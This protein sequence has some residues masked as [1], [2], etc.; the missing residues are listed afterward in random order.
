MVRLPLPADPTS[1]GWIQYAPPISYHTIQLA[2]VTSSQQIIHFITSQTLQTA[3][4]HK[5]ILFC[6]LA[7]CE[8]GFADIHAGVSGRP[9]SGRSTYSV[10][11]YIGKTTSTCTCSALTRPQD[12]VITA[13]CVIRYPVYTILYSSG[14]LDKIKP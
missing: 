2:F 13:S 12:T 14:I 1:P 11:I 3:L 7:P 8:F 10:R 5:K 4:H 9:S 6:Y